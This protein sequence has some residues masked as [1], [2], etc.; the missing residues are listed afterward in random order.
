MA[1]SLYVPV[2]RIGK[3]SEHP[4]ASLLSL[5]QVLGYQV[6][7]GLVEDPNGS[8]VRKFLKDQI[9]E[10]GKRIPLVEDSE[11][12]CFFEA[13]D[14]R[15]LAIGI[16]DVETVNF[17]FQ[18]NEGDLVVYFPGDTVL[19][20]EWAE[21]F[22]VKN[23]LKSGNRVAKIALRGE[24]SFGLVVRLPEGVNWIEGEN[25]ADFYEAVKYEPPIK[26]TAGDAA[27][28]DSEIDPYFEKFTDIQNGRLYTE[29]FAKGEQVVFSEKIHGTNVRLGYINGHRV[30]GSMELRRKEPENGDFQNSTYW[31]PWSIPGVKNL[32]EE[33]SKTHKVVELFGEVYGNSIQKGFVYDADKGLGFRSFGLKIDERFLDWDKFE[34]LC[35]EYGIPVVPV[36]YV[37]PFDM[38]LMLKI[39]E[40]ESTIGNAPVMEGGVCVSMPES[41][42]P[43]VGRKVLK[44]ISNRYDLLKNKPD[45]KDV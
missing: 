29:V 38:Q 25:V 19:T 35:N 17:S 28:Y 10:K 42:H 32:L 23:L 26:T 1:T 31:F 18:Y 11:S 12:N 3:V 15:R 45:C 43:K 20:D 44:F 27:A 9:D 40:N 34:V 16:N 24:A 30:A 5:A 2:T 21:T 4:N 14:G 7:V 33:L 36:L 39:I 6:V 8:I 13:K 37:G 22:G 41:I